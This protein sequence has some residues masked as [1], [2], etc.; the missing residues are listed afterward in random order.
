[1]YFG[2][3][4]LPFSLPGVTVNN[5]H[6]TDVSKLLLLVKFPCGLCA[7]LCSPFFLFVLSPFPSSIFREV[8]AGQH[9]GLC[10]NSQHRSSVRGGLS[11]RLQ[12]DGGPSPF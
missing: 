10:R 3:D 11:G 9:L 8:F 1:M 6:D 4:F 5:A 2:N 12:G 7:Y